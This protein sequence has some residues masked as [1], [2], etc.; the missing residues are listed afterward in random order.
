M[1]KN[2]ALRPLA[3]SIIAIMSPS[4]YAFVI[5]TENPDF[6]LRWDN[7]V[8]YNSAFR[9]KGASDKLTSSV[10]QD[11]GDRDFSKGLISNRFDVL[12][13]LDMSYQ[14]FGARLSG[15]GW[16]D[17]VYNES[18]D[19][20][21]P[22]T[23]N[24]FS[25]PF[26]EFTS[27]TE[28]LHGRKAELLDAFVYGRVPIGDTKATFRAGR[29]AL[30]WGESLFFGAN[31]IAG[32]MAPID[33]V[34]ALSVPN[35]QFKELIRPVQQFSG[36][37]QLTPDVSIGAYYQ[38]RWEETKLPA[39]GSYFSTLD[40]IGDGAERLIAG[41]PVIP[42]GGPLAFFRG[43]DMKARNSGQGGLQVRFSVDETDYGIYAIRYHDKT[44]QLYLRPGALNP[45]SGQ[46]GEYRW[47]FPEDITA[48]GASFSRTFGDYNIAGE[49]SVRRNTPLISGGAV[50]LTGTGDNDGNPLYAVGNSLH[51]QVSWLATLGP[52]FISNEASFLGEVAWNRRT[53]ITKNPD[54]LSPNADRD[55][56][57]IRVLYEP[58]YRQFFSGV[59]ISVPLGLGFGIGNSSVV[60]S[61]N[62]DHV[63]DVSVGLKATYLSDWKA[64]LT[65][66]HFFGPEGTFL[67]DT[68]FPS[69]KQ[70][71]K[72]RD[73]VSLSLQRTF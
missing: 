24:S 1:N 43:K 25:R 55:A 54:L 27:D 41:P 53:S 39:A 26:D 69:Y 7:T 31:G 30:I 12:S 4:V 68:S 51:A 18:N 9:V 3:I 73:F 23:V 61:F 28:K 56:A 49:V 20:N 8:K 58:S 21:S 5:D 32:G 29:H 17:T 46:I 13:E 63:G 59:D 19:N 72:D 15:A 50:D 42:G 65:Y 40:V 37:L 11:D 14:G 70:S 66:T 57:N 22:S 34:K 6:K 52:S 44:P 45:V 62:G 35:T 60:G 36:Q 48:Y 47:V 38:W 64:G 2:K 33:A 71:M 16:Y 67:D 10:N